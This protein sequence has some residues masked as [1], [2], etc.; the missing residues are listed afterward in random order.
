M[1]SHGGEQLRRSLM[2]VNLG[3]PRSFIV[4]SRR[5]IIAVTWSILLVHSCLRKVVYGFIQTSSSCSSFA[6]AAARRPVGGLG[7]SCS[8]PWCSRPGPVRLSCSLGIRRGDNSSFRGGGGLQR[9][10]PP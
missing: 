1:G 9:R 7:G 5:E 2:K 4:R 8:I 6:P 3:C 10:W